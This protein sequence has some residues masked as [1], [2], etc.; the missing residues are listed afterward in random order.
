MQCRR[1]NALYMILE[2]GKSAMRICVFSGFMHGQETVLLIT[3]EFRQPK[4][5]RYVMKVKQFWTNLTR[6]IPSNKWFTQFQKS[7]SHP[8]RVK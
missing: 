8:V 1:I 5:V 7:L 4:G 6:R 2:K 3:I